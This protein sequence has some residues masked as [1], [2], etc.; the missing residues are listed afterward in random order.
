MEN[1]SDSRDFGFFDLGDV[2]G[3]L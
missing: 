3:I 1:S 2:I